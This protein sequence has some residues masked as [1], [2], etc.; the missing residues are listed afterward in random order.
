MFS[1]VKVLEKTELA[2]T[3]SVYFYVNVLMEV[4]G[5]ASSPRHCHWN[6]YE[7]ALNYSQVRKAFGK[8]SNIKQYIQIV[9][10]M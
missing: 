4:S 8:S 3:V 9:I 10:C 7:L 2:E 1:D 6:L 5:I